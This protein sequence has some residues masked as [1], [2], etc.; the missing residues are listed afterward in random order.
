MSNY[1]FELVFLETEDLDASE[2]VH[3]VNIW[4]W[5]E[6]LPDVMT[7]TSEA[8]FHRCG[9]TSPDHLIAVYLLQILKPLD[10]IFYFSKKKK[11]IGKNILQTTCTWHV[12]HVTYEMTKLEK[13][14]KYE[15]KTKNKN[16]NIKQKNKEKIDITREESK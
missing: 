11:N 1:Q 8:C 6:K 10:T 13:K 15:K 7:I 3:W 14:L 5:D 16:K 12:P 4:L 9:L 2:T